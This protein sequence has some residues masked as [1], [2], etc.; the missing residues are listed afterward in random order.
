MTT[1]KIRNINQTDDFCRKYI[2]PRKWWFHHSAGGEGWHI[3]FQK[4][5]LTIKDDKKAV[6]FILQFSDQFNEART[7]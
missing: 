5:T 3:D 2:G 7:Q 6:M 4:M 1:L